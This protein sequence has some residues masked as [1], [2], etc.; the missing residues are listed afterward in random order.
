[1][2]RLQEEVTAEQDARLAD[3]DLAQVCEVI[4][5]EPIAVIDA[6][7]LEQQARLYRQL[8]RDVR[9]ESVGYGAAVRWRL[10]QY[11]AVFGGA[12]RQTAPE[13][14]WGYRPNPKRYRKLGITSAAGAVWFDADT[15]SF[16]EQT[17]ASDISLREYAHY[18]TSLSGLAAALSFT[19]A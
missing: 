5:A 12:L 16:E 14:P 3:E 15:P 1:M 2:R 13:A 6:L 19:A 9:I 10:A 4:L 11:R 8:F 17:G 7:P 18:T